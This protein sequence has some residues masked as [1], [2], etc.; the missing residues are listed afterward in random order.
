MVSEEREGIPA[1]WYTLWSM[2]QTEATVSIQRNTAAPNTTLKEHGR[3]QN[4]TDACKPENTGRCGLARPRA[5]VKDTRQSSAREDSNRTR[6][7]E[8]QGSE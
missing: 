4:T 8:F 1:Q 2:Q 5:H 3:N 6:G 7:K